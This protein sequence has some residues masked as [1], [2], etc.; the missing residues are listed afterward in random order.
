MILKRLLVTGLCVFVVW[1]G[2]LLNSAL[3]QQ[4]DF[5][6]NNLESDVRS[7]QLRLQQL[8]L[9]VGKNNQL[10]V[11]D[12]PQSSPNAR[13]NLSQLQQ[14]K[15]FKNLANLVVELNQ[16]INK[17]TIRVNQLEKLNIK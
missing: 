1:S 6:V 11:A 15:M 5:R 16:K 10:P 13:Q 9:M 14:E 8:E 2:V 12:S 7:L 4:V 3:P 17:L